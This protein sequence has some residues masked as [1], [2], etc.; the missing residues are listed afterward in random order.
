MSLH[1]IFFVPRLRR[2]GPTSS[3]RTVFRSGT[4]AKQR[5]ESQHRAR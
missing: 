5:F 2:A 4:N 1:R 3:T